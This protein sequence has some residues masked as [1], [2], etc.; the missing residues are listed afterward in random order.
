M[1]ALRDP[2]HA[3]KLKEYDDKYRNFRRWHACIAWTDERNASQERRKL[4]KERE[5]EKEKQRIKMVMEKRRLRFVLLHP[6]WRLYM[7]G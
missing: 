1:K 4:R 2:R 6:R 5:A 7:C 3:A